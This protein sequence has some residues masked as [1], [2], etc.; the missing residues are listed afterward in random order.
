MGPRTRNA[1]AAF[2]RDVGLPRT[3]NAD[4][5]TL[6]S[7]ERELQSRS[8]ARSRAA[9]T[10]PPATSSAVGY[11]AASRTASAITGDITV[12]ANQIIFANGAALGLRQV[13]DDSSN[14]Y[15]VYPPANPEL[16]QGSTLCGQG[17]PRFIVLSQESPNSLYLKVFD[18]PD[19][20]APSAG[21][22][23]Q[24]GMCA[25]YNYERHQDQTKQA[26]AA[27]AH[28]GARLLS[29]PVEIETPDRPRWRTDHQP[30]GL[31]RVQEL[32]S[33]LGYDA[34]TPDGIMGSRT[35]EAL[36]DFQADHGLSPSGTLDQ[37]TILALQRTGQRDPGE[38]AVAKVSQQPQQLQP[39]MPLLVPQRT[40]ADGQD[41]PAISILGVTIPEPVS[42]EWYQV[43]DF[44]P[45][46]LLAT[47]PET[48]TNAQV[49]AR[50]SAVQAERGEEFERALDMLAA[51]AAA[52]NPQH[53]ADYVKL[54]LAEWAVSHQSGEVTSEMRAD[55]LIGDQVVLRPEAQVLA[56][57]LEVERLARERVALT[58]IAEELGQP[59]IASEQKGADDRTS[60]AR[61][62]LG[63]E[64]FEAFAEPTHEALL[65][66]YLAANHDILNVPA[67]AWEHYLVRHIAPGEGRS[68]S[69]ECIAILRDVRD[70]FSREDRMSA[71]IELLERALEQAGSAERTRVFRLRQRVN[72]GD[73]DSAAGV[74]AF[75][76]YSA[77]AVLGGTV[78]IRRDN[79]RAPYAYVG[80][81]TSFC[82]ARPSTG[83]LGPEHGQRFLP[84]NGRFRLT[85]PKNERIAAGVPMSASSARAHVES[86][87]GART[88]GPGTRASVDIEILIE[89]GPAL[90]DAASPGTIPTRVVAARVVHPLTGEVLHV[91]DLAPEL[92][93]EPDPQALAQL[94]ISGVPLTNYRLSYLLI[95][96]HPHMIDDGLAARLA[97]AQIRQ[98]RACHSTMLEDVLDPAR[99][100][101]RGLNPSLPMI[102]PA[103]QTESQR[104]DSDLARELEKIFAA[105]DAQW[106]FAQT[107][108][109]YD[110]RF[111]HYVEAFLFDP[112]LMEGRDRDFLARELA[113]AFRDFLDSAVRAHAPDRLT[114]VFR[115]PPVGYDFETSSLKFRANQGGEFR[116]HSE[117]LP[118]YN[119]P[120]L[121]EVARFAFDPN[122][123]G[124]LR[125]SSGG[126]GNPGLEYNC[127]G[128]GQGAG[129][130]QFWRGQLSGL[131]D[132]SSSRIV[133]P[134]LAFDRHP[135]IASVE[136]SASEAERLVSTLDFNGEG[137][138]ARTTFRIDRVET[139]EQDSQVLAIYHAILE[140]VD[141]LGR[142]GAVVASLP[143]SVFPTLDDIEEALAERN[144]YRVP[145]IEQVSDRALPDAETLDLLTVKFL[146]E[147]LTDSMVERMVLSR[148]SYEEQMRK[149]GGARA[150]GDFFLRSGEEGLT[151]LD[152]P[153][154][155]ELGELVQLFRQ[156]T[157]ERAEAV[158]PEIVLRL[159]VN[160]LEPGFF[161]YP[162][163]IG[164]DQR[165]AIGATIASCRR[166]VASR[167]AMGAPS[168]R[169]E[170]LCSR[171]E[172]A[173]DIPPI[174][175]EFTGG[176]N[177]SFTRSLTA[178]I[179]P[180]S[181]CGTALATRDVYCEG[182]NAALGEL[183]DADARL[184]DVFVADKVVHVSEMDPADPA[185]NV[186]E[187]VA[188]VDAMEITEEL[189]AH[190]VLVAT[191][192]DR[193]IPTATQKL[194][195]WRLTALSA[196][197]LDDRT[198]DTIR[199]L[200]LVDPP[201]LNEPPDDA[202]HAPA[203]EIT[204]SGP[205]I[206]GIQIGMSFDEA[207]RLINEHMD[208]GRVLSADRSWD[209]SAATGKLIPYSSGRIY[210]SADGTD[211]I[212]LYDEPPAAERI[213]V[214]ATRQ[215]LLPK[216][217]VTPL[218]VVNSLR[219]KYGPED[220][221]ISGMMSTD[222]FVWAD[223]AGYEQDGWLFRE[224][225]PGRTQHNRQAEIWRD[226]DG[227]APNWE[228]D[229]LRASTG[230]PM[231]QP[232]NFRYDDV[233]HHQD[234]PRAVAGLFEPARERGEWDVLYVWLSDLGAYIRLIQESARLL[235]SQESPG[236]GDQPSTDSQIDVKL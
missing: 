46:E 184:L 129:P 132:Y 212:V 120:I 80:P 230:F 21:P 71:A 192:S 175:I 128:T 216:G 60:A 123:S 177:P 229:H 201:Q 138:S 210:V 155:A 202:G 15:E 91:H 140:G 118:R 70:Q 170:E 223:A 13:G 139:I 196:R 7:L 75:G 146:P 166:D 215:I 50:V 108:P 213:V 217:Q 189:P 6:S 62:N 179:G 101:A 161:R 39:S 178:G 87:E 116:K 90:Y 66:L 221:I 154:R 183:A 232:L 142:S 181:A 4:S 47:P 1:L 185:G 121:P 22:L 64:D 122:S 162:S 106:S 84:R 89:T 173:R 29:S 10:S 187:L 114:T 174:S 218:A 52:A 5:P 44:V 203:T 206:L 103:W 99:L 14:V 134:V 33:F 211:L 226:Q 104:P 135:R 32:L 145:P 137:L 94:A 3:G 125:Q 151:I 112:A 233:G 205:D 231:L 198:G 8:A 63:I 59:R 26:H 57:S 188:R 38:S 133:S 42:V 159:P 167:Q 61:P 169:Q 163:A 74:F 197:L 153:N 117:L 12:S 214:G 131:T 136:M 95:R 156:W 191:G 102:A 9:P 96:D 16:L 147:A 171:M 107:T 144:R 235:Q 31:V 143:P 141:I 28:P 27:P 54:S 158:S 111:R 164:I 78:E 53:D 228:E 160:N 36:A 165:N 49:G 126:S 40:V 115:L 130:S 88:R 45:D 35:R 79:I 186:I 209:L 204:A 20:P 100:S 224:C 227:Q 172:A 34:G 207:E 72:L 11:V 113:P 176:F 200:E 98:E 43:R 168:Q 127:R 110:A 76:P 48:L 41:G 65:D 37:G 81:V 55:V 193:A 86:F 152:R 23:P 93:P 219:N 150:W 194:H 109:G 73:Y 220:T 195:R 30:R 190:P 182:V 25:S 82:T 17:S 222:L 234:C 67:I 83:L 24:S 97:G 85:I 2:Q 56:K 18:G 105:P 92:E 225:L 148:W 119:G 157:V 199:Y 68:L 149:S 236:A 51:V 180:R 19:A 58:L 124:F 208:V 77:Q 69:D